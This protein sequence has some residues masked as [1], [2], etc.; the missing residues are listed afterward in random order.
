MGDGFKKGK[1]TEIIYLCRIEIETMKL[2]SI[3]QICLETADWISQCEKL[4]NES[5]LARMVWVAMQMGL[6]VARLVLEGEL[7]RRAE[8]SMEWSE[9]QKCGH[10]LQSKGWHKR[11]I[12]TLVGRIH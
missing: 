6:W 2:T 1:K 5:S 12:E 11:E 3:E 7:T 8:E 4:R 9:C 10:R